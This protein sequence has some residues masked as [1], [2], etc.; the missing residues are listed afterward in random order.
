MFDHA[1]REALHECCGLLAG[2][3]GLVTQHYPATNADASPTTYS[4]DSRQLIQIHRDVREA[5]LEIV[6]VYHSHTMS[7]A[8][9]SPT[10]VNRSFWEG[11]DIETYPGCVHL[12][13][14][15]TE[16]DEPVLR[17]FRIPD[18]STIEDVPVTVVEDDQSGGPGR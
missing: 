6:S 16:G 9:P 18:R 8:Y 7:G 5:G 1:R 4:I 15:L 14:S 12:I 13:I 11:T 3:D 17:G 2:K 10:D